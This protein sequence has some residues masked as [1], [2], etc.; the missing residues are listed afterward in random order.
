MRTIV[1]IPEDQIKALDSL[2]KK[3]NLS[4]AELVRRAVQAY[5]EVEQGRTAGA[6][7]AYFGF[8]Q[9]VPDAFGG[10]DSLDYQQDM[11]GEWDDRDKSYSNWGFQEGGATPYE[12]RKDR[13]K[14]E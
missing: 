9:G 6:V 7:D 10:M 8:L 1:D 14:G 12:H 2:G 11:R 4:R 5:L 3:D 13:N